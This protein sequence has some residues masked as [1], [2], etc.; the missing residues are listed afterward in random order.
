MR[1]PQLPDQP[2]SLPLPQ[3]LLGAGGEKMAFQRDSPAHTSLDSR[4][5]PSLGVPPK[6][7]PGFSWAPFKS[8]L[9]GEPVKNE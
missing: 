5:D 1:R 2:P 6:F 7:R 9:R 8:P 3:W 4:K